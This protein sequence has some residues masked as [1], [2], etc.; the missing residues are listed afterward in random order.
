[1]VYL[2]R[3]GQTD[4]NLFKR[5]NGCTDTYLNKTGIEQ[6]KLQA[7]NL[8]DVCFDAC[9]CSPQTRARQFCEII[10]KGSV[11]FDDRL[12]E[13]VCGEFEGTE[14]TADAMKLFL[15][16][17]ENGDMGTEKLEAFIERNYNLC[18]EITEK[19]KGKNILIVTHALNTRIINY[20]F[21]GKPENYDFSKRVV[22]NGGLL[23]FE[24]SKEKPDI[25]KCC[26]ILQ[27]EHFLLRL[28]RE[29]DAEDLLGCYSDPKS[30][31]IFDYENCISDFCYTTAEEMTDCIRFWLKEYLERRFIR[32]AVVDRKSGKAIGTIEMFSDPSLLP[33]TTGGVLRIDLA[34]QF[35]TEECLAELLQLANDR[36]YGLFGAEMIV[37]KG[38]PTAQT[39]ITSLL[40][41]GYIPYDWASPDREYYYSRKII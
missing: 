36:F 16:A 8:R 28:V 32:F 2:V 26:P 11:V 3:H 29:S 39:R 13:I 18:D 5:F 7:E 4:W 41:N 25:Y 21:N 15:K 27:T 17:I 40:N 6:A 37:T 31:P 1:M 14:E 38:K 22:G 23:I 30:Q 10:Y 34:S 35:E 19:Y 24:N 12:A 9:F 33:D 20:Y